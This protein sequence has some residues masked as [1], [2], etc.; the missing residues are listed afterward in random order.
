M[1]IPW[2]AALLLYLGSPKYM[3]AVLVYLRLLYIA[4]ISNGQRPVLLSC[5]DKVRISNLTRHHDAF[6]TDRED[7]RTQ[8]RIQEKS[9]ACRCDSHCNAP[10]TCIYWRSMVFLP[11]IDDLD[12]SPFTRGRRNL[13]DSVTCTRHRDICAPGVS[14]P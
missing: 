4:N 7:F 5:T 3:N 10:A 9:D 6:P 12:R 8:L 14:S 11:L 1:P 2:E 13:E